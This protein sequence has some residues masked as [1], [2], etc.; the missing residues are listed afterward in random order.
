MISGTAPI[1]L[2]SSKGYLDIVSALI[3]GGA[4][5]NVATNDGYSPLFAATRE[6]KYEVVVELLAAG[7]LSIY[8]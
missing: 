6:E 7:E 4:D 8:I 3:G 5:V 2:C 1:L